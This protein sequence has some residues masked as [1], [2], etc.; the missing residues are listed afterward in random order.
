MNR[1]LGYL[2]VY[3]LLN[4]DGISILTPHYGSISILWLSDLLLL[5]VISD[6]IMAVV[7]VARVRVRAPQF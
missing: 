6:L 7:S 5:I 1:R 4:Q 2:K 3:S